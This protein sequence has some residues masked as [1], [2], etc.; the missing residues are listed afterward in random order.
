MNFHSNKITIMRYY[1]RIGSHLIIS[2]LLQVPFPAEH[3][4]II[5]IIIIIM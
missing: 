3:N 2:H 1:C 5:I 4:T